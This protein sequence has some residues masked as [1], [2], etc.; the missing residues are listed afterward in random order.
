MYVKY[1]Y[2][3]DKVSKYFMFYFII[4]RYLLGKGADPQIRDSEMNIAL[5]WSAFAGSMEITESLIDYGSNINLSN[6][7]GDTPL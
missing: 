1:Y 5:H 2:Y 3:P 4:F 7:H 6:V